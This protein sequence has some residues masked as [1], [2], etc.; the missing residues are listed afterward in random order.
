MYALT[1]TEDKRINFVSRSLPIGDEIGV[2]S[3][4]EGNITDY[5]YINNQFYYDPLP[6][7]QEQPDEVQLLKSRLDSLMSYTGLTGHWEG[8]AFIVE[9][10]QVATGDYLDPILWSPGDSIT[11]GLWYYTDDKDL[12]HEAIV[13]G[14]PFDFNDRN[15]FD[16]I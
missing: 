6:P 12:P 3:I 4:P 14:T 9:K 15:F 10:A 2:E 1:L 13:S 16:D 5:K 7:V 8:S 11:T